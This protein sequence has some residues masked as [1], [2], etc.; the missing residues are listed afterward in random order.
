VLGAE[1]G[2]EEELVP[3]RGYDLRLIPKAAFPRRPNVSALRFPRTLGTA[4]SRTGRIVDEVGAEVVV[5]FG[6]YVSP[7]AY[8][9][10]RRRRVPIVVHEGNARAGLASRLGA[11]FT[12]HVATTFEDTT[13]PHAQVVGLPLRTEIT[14]MD[15]SA[16]R[17][18]AL[19]QFGLEPDRPTVLVTGG[20]LGARRINEAFEHSVGPL[21]SAGIQ[22]LHVTGRGKE[23]D[24]G[25]SAPGDAAYVVL[26]YADRMELCY[27]AADLVVTR[28]GAGMVCETGAIGLPAVFVPL[29]IGNGEQRLNARGAVHAGGALLVADEDFTPEWIRAELIP[30]VRD[31]ARLERMS[32]AARE[33]GRHDA[34]RALVA[35]IDRAARQTEERDGR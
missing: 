21:R 19:A 11:R 10:A 29:P 34:D 35:M 14:A 28:A 13:L 32:A 20:S 4:I 24:P 6:G 22:V 8:L 3:A 9:A 16:T 5:G 26:P 12:T 33:M 17:P 25:P 2:L 1:G 23:F 15:R 30:L 27:A 7:P 31:R 18:A